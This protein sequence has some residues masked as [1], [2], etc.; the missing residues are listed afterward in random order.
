MRTIT[1]T[2]Y[3]APLREGGSL[4]ALVEAD[5]D[6]LY[7]LKFRGAGQGPRALVAELLAGEVARLRRPAGPRDRLRA[8]RPADRGRRTRPRDPGPARRVGG[9]QP[10]AR[11]PARLAGL[12]AARRDRPG[13]RGRRRVARRAGHERRPHAPQPQPAALARRAVADRPRR[14]VLPPPRRRRAGVGG[15]ERRADELPADRRPRPR[16]VR[17]AD[18]PTPIERLASKLDGDA[19]QELRALVPPDWADPDPYIEFLARAAARAAGVRGRG[20][21]CH[22]M[23]R[24]PTRCCA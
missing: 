11:L 7:V 15:D 14:R 9:P 3:V 24:S 10:G 18:W 22:P 17:R 13:V 4:P 16:A 20:P 1:P 21:R 19:L 12:L 23:K 2:R 6:G 5:D 8:A